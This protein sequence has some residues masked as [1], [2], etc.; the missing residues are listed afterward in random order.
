MID[1][2]AVDGVDVAIEGVH[3]TRWCAVAWSALRGEM[4]DRAGHEVHYVRVPPCPRL[5]RLRAIYAV[6]RKS[7]RS[8]WEAEPGTADAPTCT[9]NT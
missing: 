1:A 8:A 6:Y 7:A 2:D 5:S 9:P 4:P 3:L